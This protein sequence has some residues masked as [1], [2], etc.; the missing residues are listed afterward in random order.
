M[1]RPRVYALIVLGVPALA[2]A[3]CQLDCHADLIALDATQ[4]NRTDSRSEGP[5]AVKSDLPVDELKNR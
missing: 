1:R 5:T 4:P 3:D 2:Q